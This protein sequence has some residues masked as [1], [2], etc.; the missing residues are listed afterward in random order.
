MQ[1]LPNGDEVAEALRHLLA[2]DLQEAVVHPEIRHQ[3][4]MEG[5]T[6]LRD[7]VLVV[8]K[9]EINAAAVDVEDFA[10]MLPRHRRAFDVP[11]GP[12]RR[13][14]AARRW[15]GGFAGF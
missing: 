10:E 15:P 7:L 3:A 9:S 12:A 2:F 5:A 6:R 11:A 13:G 8:R 1:Q 14:D 4:G